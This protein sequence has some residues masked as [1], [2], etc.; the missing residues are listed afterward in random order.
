MLSEIDNS[1]NNHKLWCTK[2]FLQNRNKQIPPLVVDGIKL[3]TATEKSNAL[4]D[5]FGATNNNN[6][7]ENHNVTHTIWINNAVSRFMNNSYVNVSDNDLVN[8]AEVR[9]IVK[10]LKN[11][12]SPGLDKIHNNLLKKLPPR[13]RISSIHLQLLPKTFLLS[14]KV[15]E[16][17]KITIAACQ[18]S[19]D[20][21]LE[22]NK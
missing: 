9:N 2:K 10:K 7:L 22:L 8:E 11:S 4:A 14:Y 15:E 5:Q 6:S 20:Q 19:T 12:K 18:R 21:Y 3:L 1:D 16:A 17:R 13:V